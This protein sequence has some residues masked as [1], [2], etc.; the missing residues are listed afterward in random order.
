MAL[1]SCPGRPGKNSRLGGIRKGTI[2]IVPLKSLKM[3]PR[4]TA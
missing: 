3:H 2:A 4:F 1:I